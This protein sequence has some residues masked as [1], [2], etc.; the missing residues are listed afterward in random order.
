MIFDYNYWTKD[1]L[2]AAAEFKIL[3]LVKADGEMTM[4]TL[5]CEVPDYYK[6]QNK[7]PKICFQIQYTEIQAQ[8]T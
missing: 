7:K 5:P 4:V 1:N 6:S 3:D 8:T 2:I